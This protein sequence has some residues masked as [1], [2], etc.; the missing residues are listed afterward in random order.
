MLYYPRSEAEWDIIPAAKRTMAPVLFLGW[1]AG[2]SVDNIRYPTKPPRPK[3]T[4]QRIYER[5]D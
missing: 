2:F 3:V 5:L 4:R 1:D